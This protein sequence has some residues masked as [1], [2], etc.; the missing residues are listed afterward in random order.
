MF[1]D[2]STYNW[3]EFID[4][5]LGEKLKAIKEFIS[6]DGVH[7]KAMLYKMLTLIRSKKE[8]NRLNIARFA[9]LIARLRPNEKNTD[10]N[11]LQER[12]ESYNNFAKKMYNWIQSA[13]DC[14]QLVTAIYIYV[15]MNRER[16]VNGN[17]R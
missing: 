17:D 15:Y 5:V 16:E 3:D 10:E 9:Y 1:D 11:K 13:R 6:V 14:R 7:S 8:E 4:C 12:L 2:T